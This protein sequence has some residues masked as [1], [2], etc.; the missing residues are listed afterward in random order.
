MTIGS[1]VGTR[2]DGEEITGQEQSK[3]LPMSEGGLTE[4]GAPS[5]SEVARRLS[6]NSPPTTAEIQ[7]SSDLENCDDG[8]KVYTNGTV[9]VVAEEETIHSTEAEGIN[10]DQSKGKE[11]IKEHKEPW[12]NMFRNNRAT[13]NGMNLSYFPPQIVNGQTM[14]QLEEKEVQVEEDKWKSVA[15]PDVYMHEEGYYTVKFQ[16]LSDMNEILYIVPYTINNRPIILKQWC[17]DFDFGSEFLAEIPLWVNFPKLPPNCLDGGSLSRIASA[18]GV[19]LFA[20]ECTTKQTRISYAKMLIEVNVTKPIPQQITVMDPNRGTFM[21]EVVLEWR[22]Q[23]CDKCQKIGHQCQPAVPTKEELLKKRRPWKKVTQTWQYKGPIQPQ[24]QMCEQRNEPEQMAK[25]NS[26]YSTA[27]KG[28][29]EIEQEQDNQPP[30]EIC[31]IDLRPNAGGLVETRVKEPN[32]KATIKG[33]APDRLAGAPVTIN[34]IKDFTECVKDIGVTELQ[35]KGNY[36]T[37]TNKQHGIDR[38]SSKI[39][40]SIS[41]HCPMQL[42]LQTTQHCVKVN[43]KFFNVWTEHASFMGL[44]ESIWKQEYDKDSMKKVWC[45]LMALQ[46]VLRDTLK[47]EK[48]SMIEESALR[49]KSRTKWIQ[50]GDANNKY[51]SAIIQER[52]Q[53]KQIRGITSLDV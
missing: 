18:I 27:K 34:E 48:W 17:P 43:F 51:F 16:N 21:Q 44:V 50:L 6:L 20:D 9:T 35:W 2:V 5:R 49:Q 52:T 39:D 46:P 47:L 22:P 4:K 12:V 38:I 41:D 53:K 24:E 10:G 8:K 26:S 11:Q 28:K 33:I 36:Y 14:V 25:E 23:Y 1:L 7:E 42:L 31:Q 45:K 29:Q 30:G 37:W 3:T 13:N 40:K 15:K 32:M 19:P